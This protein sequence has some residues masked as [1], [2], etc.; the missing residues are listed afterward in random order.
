M[1][2]VYCPGDVHWARLE[3]SALDSLIAAFPA[4]K[5]REIRDSNPDFQINPNSDVCRI[6]LLP[7]PAKFGRR[8]F[9]RSPV[10]LF[11]ERQNE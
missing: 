11:T 4:W 1:Q 5:R 10:I 8:P 3:A 2:G 9:P 7:V 6:C